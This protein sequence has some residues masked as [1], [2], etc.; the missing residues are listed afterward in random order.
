MFKFLTTVMYTHKPTV[1]TPVNGHITHKKGAN[2][3][4]RWY[5]AAWHCQSVNVLL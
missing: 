4:K 3:R 2:I 5:Y 1:Y